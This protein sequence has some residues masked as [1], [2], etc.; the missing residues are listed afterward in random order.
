ML[1]RGSFS[2]LLSCFPYSHHPPFLFF[3][4][5][6]FLTFQTYL[7]LT[8]LSLQYLPI[9]VSVFSLVVLH[10]LHLPFFSF[11]IFL[12]LLPS[13]SH[14]SFQTYVHLPRTCLWRYKSG[15]TE[16]NCFSK[17][18]A[19]QSLSGEHMSPRAVPVLRRGLKRNLPF[20][21]YSA[22]THRTRK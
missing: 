16:A 20:V 6:P 9:F 8:P 5:F 1:E 21:R 7:S 11:F 18:G 12:A 2:T 15:M 17:N 10:F 19:S 4:R 22:I 14:C 3:F 13:F